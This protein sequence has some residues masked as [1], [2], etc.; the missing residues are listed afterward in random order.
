MNNDKKNKP[1]NCNRRTF[2]GS[3]AALAAG[4]ALKASAATADAR[5]PIVIFSKHLQF[6]DYQQVADALPELGYDGADITVRP[7]GHV[8]P[9][10]VEEDLPIFVKAIRKNGLDVPMITTNISGADD[11]YAESILRT[12][13]SLGI[14]FYRIGSWR[15]DE[16]R[17]II[18][19]LQEYNVKMKK[20]AALNQQ[21]NM[22][23]GYHNHSGLRYIGGPVFDLYEMLKDVDPQ[24]IGSNFDTGHAVVEGGGGA[25]ITNFRLMADRIKMSA[26]K[27][28]TWGKTEKGWKHQFCPMGQGTVDWKLALSLFKKIGF[29][30]PFSIHMEY[31]TQG[32]TPAEI[33]KNALA[34][35]KRDQEV[36]RELMAQAGWK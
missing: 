17:G 33:E 13:S 16:S 5:P 14:K 8:L 32:D 25:W 15:Y 6:L 21:Y 1:S 30:G 4:M 22:Q 26:V 11:A 7:R 23:A 31:E 10:N 19:Q 12:A 28:F 29:T 34:D 35:L 9:E 36:L 3:S 2:L 18:E 27:D 24:W 20:L